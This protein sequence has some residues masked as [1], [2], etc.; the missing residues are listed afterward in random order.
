MRLS[1]GEAI[2]PNEF[3]T[4]ELIQA[5]VRFHDTEHLEFEH[6]SFTR[7]Q[8]PNILLNTSAAEGLCIFSGPAGGLE[9][10][11]ESPTHDS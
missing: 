6:R 8:K 11:L 10:A 2:S 3:V 4:T 5:K 9:L 7:A 1:F